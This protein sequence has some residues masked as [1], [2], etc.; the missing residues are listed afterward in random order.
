MVTIKSHPL[1]DKLF[2]RY[3]RKIYLSERDDKDVWENYHKEAHWAWNELLNI[4]RQHY[5]HDPD[6]DLICL[7]LDIYRLHEVC[8]DFFRNK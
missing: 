7:G 6:A 3:M 8:C 2:S 1:C 5:S 4:C